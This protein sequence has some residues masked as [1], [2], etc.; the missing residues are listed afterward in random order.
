MWQNWENSII[1]DAV[2]PVLQNA[3]RILLLDI[4]HDL[5]D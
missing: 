1:L 4:Y 3:I 5:R 2:F